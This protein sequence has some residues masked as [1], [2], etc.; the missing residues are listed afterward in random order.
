MREALQPILSII[1]PVYNAESHIGKCLKS[2]VCNQNSQFEV[3]VV[4]DGSKD[5]SLRICKEYECSDQR[6]CV[7]MQKNS[8]VSSARNK[9]LDHAKG[10]YVT[11]CDAD[12]YYIENGIDLLIDILKQNHNELFLMAFYQ[13]QENHQTLTK[14]LPELCPN[15]NLSIKNIKDNFWLLLNGGMLN[16]PWNKVFLRERIEVLGLRF[17]EDV[18]FSEDGIF[19]VT[20][21][22]SITDIMFVNQPI[23][24]YVIHQ[25]QVSQKKVNNFFYMMCQAYDCIDEFISEERMDEQYWLEWFKV[26][27][28]T[29]YH[30]DGDMSNA[31]EIFETKRTKEM[32]AHYKPGNLFDRVVFYFLRKRRI[33][34]IYAVITLRSTCGRIKKAL[35]MVRNS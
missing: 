3:I 32:I 12:D 8:G 27:K 23:Y 4:D 19:N 25:G 28:N 34:S 2:I 18:T 10:K 33:K 20:Y 30:Q 21:L 24:N 1:I 35:G 14:K 5:Q 15:G 11:F 22:K 26:I 13:Q 17:R 7:Y 9:G 29:F 16:A 6:I 31:N